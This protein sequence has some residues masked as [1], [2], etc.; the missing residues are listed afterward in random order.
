MSRS[1]RASEANL[2]RDVPCPVLCRCQ[3]GRPFPA[4]LAIHDGPRTCVLAARVPQDINAKGAR[5]S[6]PGHNKNM[7][8]H[9]HYSSAEH[10]HRVERL[11]H[12][13]NAAFFGGKKSAGDISK[14][15]KDWKGLVGCNEQ[16]YAS[17]LGEA[18]LA[19]ISDPYARVFFVHLLL[20]VPL[21]RGRWPSWT[22]TR[23][24][25]LNRKQAIATAEFIR[26]GADLGD[27]SAMQAWTM[28]WQ[29]VF[30]HG[31]DWDV[32][33]THEKGP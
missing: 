23:L 4:S 22:R 7:T 32:V 16:E 21:K 9:D 24:S 25:T 17:Q 19:I 15:K 2:V 31:G 6:A 8:L 14:L 26:L 29:A 11:W 5:W 13:I 1:M 33:W 18:M 28:L 30:Q 10:Q 3:M 27:T 12:S 20:L